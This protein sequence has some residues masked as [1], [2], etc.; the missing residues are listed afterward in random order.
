M[1]RRL[2]LRLDPSAIEPSLLASCAALAQALN[3]ELQAELEEDE[4]LASLAQLP[5]I[6]EVSRDS[7]AARTLDAELLR[8]RAER[9][10]Q[11]LSRE[12][13]QIAQGHKIHWQLIRVSAGT[14]LKPSADSAVLH[15]P[16]AQRYRSNTPTAPRHRYLAVVDAGDEA[17]ARALAN[18]RQIARQLDRP[19]LLLAL[20]S[21]PWHQST[22]PPEHTDALTSLATLD[23]ATL[24]AL[25]RAWQAD[26]L[27]L[28]APLLTNRTSPLQLP[29]V[30]I[31]IT[32]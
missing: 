16:R 4:R 5:F 3:A 12:L 20:P 7:A 31:L 15:A 9:M 27:I 14:P 10:V 25:L 32:P 1:I 30:Q 21:S 6:T 29:G 28:P 2:I 22:Q 19:L 13:E 18:A 23:D 11:Q 26:L 8:R 24:R 17:S